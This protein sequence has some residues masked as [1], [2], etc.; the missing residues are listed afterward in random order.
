MCVKA[1]VNDQG[2]L[3]TQLLRSEV[4]SVLLSWS[5]SMPEMDHKLG[6]GICTAISALKTV[7]II[8]QFTKKYP[9]LPISGKSYEN[10]EI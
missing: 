5:F 7:G 4:G 6:R 2:A 9:K 10:H 1:R 8:L 3:I